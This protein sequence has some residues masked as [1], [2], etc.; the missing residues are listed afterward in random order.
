[1]ASSSSGVEASTQGPMTK[2][3]KGF[4][5]PRSCDRNDRLP[6][7]WT[8]REW[9]TGVGFLR[10]SSAALSSASRRARLRA[11]RLPRRGLSFRLVMLG[12]QLRPTFIVS[13]VGLPQK[14]A[15]V[16]CSSPLAPKAPRARALWARRLR[17]RSLRAAWSGGRPFGASVV[18]AELYVFSWRDAAGVAGEAR[19]PGASGA[20][21]RS[22]AP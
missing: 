14:P 18:A 7:I 12:G 17:R 13:M 10:C 1:M 5:R 9:L 2:S 16:S 15:S 8:S 19:D 6:K 11:L 3:S 22:A 4:V 21:V 20:T